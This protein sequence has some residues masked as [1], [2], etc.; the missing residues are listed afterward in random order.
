[1]YIISS[2]RLV[3]TTCGSGLAKIL[4]SEHLAFYFSFLVFWRF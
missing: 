3:I 4:I 2:N 1:M